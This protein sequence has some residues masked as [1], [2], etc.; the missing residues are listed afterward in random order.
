MWK[1]KKLR[2]TEKTKNSLEKITLKLLLS[3]S[4]ILLLKSL[5]NNLENLKSGDIE[6]TD[7]VIS[8]QVGFQ[9]DVQTDNDPVEQV[10]VSRFSQRTSGVVA[11]FQVLPLVDELVTDLHA[12]T[13]DGFAKFR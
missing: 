9:S 7:K 12:W 13:S 3:L 4:I 5:K 8:R 2:K 10:L 6:Y 1:S 11:L